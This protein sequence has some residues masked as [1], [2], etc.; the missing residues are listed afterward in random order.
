MVVTENQL[1]LGRRNKINDSDPVDKN[2][3]STDIYYILTDHLNTP[4]KVT[5]EYGVVLWSWN[6]DAFGTTL[7]NEDVDINGTDFVF[8]LRFPGQYFD[9]ESGKH[10]NYFR[11]YEPGTGRYL[12]SDPI[13]LNGGM[14]TFGYVNGN[15]LIYIDKYGLSCKYGGICP[16]LIPRPPKPKVCDDCV[17]KEVHNQQI[18]TCLGSAVGVGLVFVEY[19]ACSTFFSGIGTNPATCGSCAAATG[20]LGIAAYMF[21]NNIEPEC[22]KDC[23][24]TCK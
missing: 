24:K 19:T 3:V 14:N 22:D 17:S 23:I 2:I 4:R 9:S 15:P 10:Y 21:C 11:D 8:N 20:G 5:D 18:A 1:S 6:S 13:G 7:A 12:E 16:R